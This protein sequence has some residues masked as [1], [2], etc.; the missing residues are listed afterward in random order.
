MGPLSKIKGVTA[1]VIDKGNWLTL[2]DADIMFMERPWNDA[3]KEG[4]Q[5]ASAFNVPT[6]IDFDDDLFSIPPWNPSHKTYEP[7][8][9]KDSIKEICKLATVITVTTEQLKNVY[10]QFNPNVVVIPNALNDYNF[11]WRTDNWNETNTFHWRGSRTHRGDLM[12][13]KNEI[14]DLY[15]TTPNHRWSWFGEE[16]W[17]VTE[18]M[19]SEDLIINSETE[20]VRYFV[21]THNLLPSY[22]IVPLEDNT[23]NRGKSN[24]AW[25]EATWAGAIT[26]APDWEVW[27]QPGIVNFKDGTFKDT[28]KKVISDP[29]LCRKLWTASTDHIKSN[30]MLTS[31]N[32]KRIDLIKGILKSE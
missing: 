5:Y 3:H 20:I 12:K 25:L 24:I 1:Q 16:H 9:I 4:I 18:E 6:W 26:F 2:S 14:V 29:K 19:K 27:H 23:F 13:Y 8:K 22:A 11:P 15:K 7:E 30:F 28:V 21:N 32:A 10:G 17:M 31:V